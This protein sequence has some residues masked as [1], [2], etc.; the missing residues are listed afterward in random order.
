LRS[1]SPSVQP[2]L[3]EFA[4]ERVQWVTGRGEG[5][6]VEPDTSTADTTVLVLLRAFHLADV[7]QGAREFAAALDAAEAEAAAWCRSWART[8]FLFGN[9]ANLTPPNRARAVAPGATA[10]WP[11]P[12]RAAADSV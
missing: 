10:A 11:G 5:E 9:P 12:F 3:A 1:A 6:R 7:V 4:V 2:R 8:R